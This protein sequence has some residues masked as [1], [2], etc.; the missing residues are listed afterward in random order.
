VN[1]TAIETIRLEALPNLLLL[2]IHTDEGLTGLGETWFGA[3]AI[4]A[5]VHESVAPALL[6]RDPLALEATARIL[7][8]Y[9]GYQGAGVELRGNS[10]VDIA[11]WDL[12]GQASSQPLYALL[13]GRTRDRIDVYNTCAGPRYSAKGKAGTTGQWGLGNSAGAER[14]EDLDA[15]LHRADEL[16]ESLLEQG[17]RGMKIWPLDALAEQS[18]GSIVPHDRLVATLEPFRKIRR[19]VGSRMEIFVELHSMWDLPAARLVLSALDEFQPYWYEDPIRATDRGGLRTLA[20][21][22]TVPIATGETLAGAPAY[23]DLIEDGAVGVVILDI[24]WVGGLTE[25]RKVA[26]IAD[27]RQLPVAAHDCTGPVVLT[28]SAHLAVSAPNAV[29]QEVVRAYY[30]GWYADLVTELPVLENGT[31]RPPEGAGLGIALQP[32]L[33]RRPGASVRRSSI[34]LAG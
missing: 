12:L 21:Q 13:G 15:F 23:L 16:A 33:V 10:A 24:S 22:T 28:A 9:L 5:Y 30:F 29:V 27:A 14:Y 3:A 8:P 2:Q 32:D 31:I 17:I 19:A 11:C 20:Q 18:A 4:E 26:A 34:D 1:I 7:R 6:G 25:A